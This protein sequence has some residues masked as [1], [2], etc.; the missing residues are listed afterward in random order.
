MASAEQGKPMDRAQQPAE[1][2]VKQEET[3]VKKEE[4]VEQRE[5]SAVKKEE[6]AVKR[7]GASQGDGKATHAG[8]PAGSRHRSWGSRNVDVFE[9]IEQIGEG[10][11][12]QVYMA[13]EKATGEIVALKKVRMDNEKEGFPITAIREIKILKNLHHE[14]VID[15]KEIVTS[16]GD[17]NKDK[18]SIYMVFEY[19]DHD[20]TGLADYPKITFTPPQIK[21]YMSQM[22]HGLHFCHK[23][24]VLHR[25]IKGSN[26]LIGNNGTLKLA[27]FGLARP[28]SLEGNAKL[29]NRVITLWYRPPE[30]LLG[31]TKYGPAVDMWSVGCIFAELLSGRPVLPG[32]NEG[33]QLDLIFKLCGSPS[34]AEWPGVSSLP[35][36]GMF[37]TDRPYKRR[38][39]EQ[40]KSLRAD[41]L[42]LLDKLLA[43]D[44]EKRLSAQDALLMDYFYN[45]PPPSK[46]CDL[47]KYEPSHEFQAKK[48]RQQMRQQREED[49]KK[50]RTHQPGQGQGQGPQHGRPGGQG[51]GYPGAGAPGMGAQ[52]PSAPAQPHGGHHQVYRS[53]GGSGLYNQGS[54]HW[55]AGPAMPPGGAPPGVAARSGYPNQRVWEGSGGD[56][57]GRPGGS[58]GGGADLYNRGGLN[59]LHHTAGGHM[60]GGGMAAPMAGMV[61]NPVTAPLDPSAM[62]MGGVAPGMAPGAA[63]MYHPPYGGKTSWLPG[64]SGHPGGSY[65]PKAE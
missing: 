23:N 49:A 63:G 19:M 65:P 15:L 62:Y 40:F 64:G 17:G 21:Y 34:E 39:R 18:G 7:E 22:L 6:P 53:G 33:E 42:E 1:V 36:Y 45:S 5:D 60:D 51:G 47:P 31:A 57:G 9:K 12:G 50:Q 4:A 37:K 52:K 11:Y 44:P 38:L 54:A 32:K 3:A 2:A 10:T 29:T 55:S 41:E 26:I 58:R 25:D 56:G 16:E 13:R 61:M 35:H 59:S 20:L 24:L 43:L 48:R 30:L 46:P 14:N 27:D 28:Y 8:R